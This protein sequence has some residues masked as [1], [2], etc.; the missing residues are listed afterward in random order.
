MYTQNGWWFLSSGG[1]YPP[2]FTVELLLLLFIVV[3]GKV[4]THSGPL[5]HTTKVSD[6]FTTHLIPLY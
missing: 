5:S 3:H 1:A 2:V 6:N 4:V